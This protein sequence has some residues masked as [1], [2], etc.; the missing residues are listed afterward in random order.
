MFSLYK[1]KE[2][3]KQQGFTLIEV[4]VSVT[5]F[6]IVTTIGLGALLSTV[7][8]SKQAQAERIALDSLNFVVDAMAREIRTGSAYTASA[9][10]G[11]TL[12]G[13]SDAFSFINQEGCEVTYRRAISTNGPEGLVQRRRGFE[14]GDNQF[15]PLTDTAI[16]DV[17]GVL[18]RVRGA[19]NTISDTRQPFVSFAVTA[20]ARASQ[21]EATIVLQSSVTQR[22]LD[23]PQ[24]S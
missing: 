23:I 5:I 16:L 14:C 22:L 21:Q 6:T 4:M 8:A 13:S 24:G 3:N 11:T 17:T 9:I 20:E 7:T 15:H 10:P 1:L 18:F 2:K 12:N 19:E